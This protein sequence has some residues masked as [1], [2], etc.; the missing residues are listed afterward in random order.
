MGFA[1]IYFAIK[2]GHFVAQN[3]RLFGFWKRSRLI[4]PS[5]L[6]ESA[7]FVRFTLWINKLECFVLGMCW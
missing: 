2:L 5:S 6:L 7:I 1:M 4:A 3:R